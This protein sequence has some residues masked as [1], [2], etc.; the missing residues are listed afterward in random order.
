MAILAA[1][2]LHELLGSVHEV[3][4]FGQPRV[5]DASFAN[6]YQKT[7]PN[8]FRIINYADTV[9]HVPPSA[10]GFVHGGH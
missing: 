9:P 1:L 4:T 5:G 10:F 7:A 2:D 8:T 6:F 3:Y